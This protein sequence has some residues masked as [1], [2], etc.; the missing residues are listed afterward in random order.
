MRSW[1]GPA[2]LYNVSGTVDVADVLV[3]VLK[4]HLK[5]SQA[6]HWRETGGDVSVWCDVDVLTHCWSKLEQN[7]SLETA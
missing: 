4:P 5:R 2:L 7:M 3:I 6:R 1:G